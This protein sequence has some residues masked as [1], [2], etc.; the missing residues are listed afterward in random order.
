MS[1]QFFCGWPMYLESPAAP[2]ISGVVNQVIAVLLLLCWLLAQ[3]QMCPTIEEFL[4]EL[5]PLVNT[6]I[7]NT[8]V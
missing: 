3:V 5:V 8:D 1:S 4:E 7:L 2:L 6:I